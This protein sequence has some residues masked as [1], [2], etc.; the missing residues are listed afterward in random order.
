MEHILTVTLLLF[1]AGFLPVTC[2]TIKQAQPG[3]TVIIWCQHNV[4]V[5]GYIY[6]FKQNDGAVPMTIVSMLYSASLQSR[7][8]MYFNS[9]KK[10]HLVMDL[11]SKSTTLTIMNVSISDSGFYFCGAMEHQ[12]HFGSGTQL[13]V[14]EKK[15]VSVKNETGIS[16][17][18]LSS[19]VLSGNTK[20]RS[21]KK[22]L[23]V[24]NKNM[25]KRS[26]IQ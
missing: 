26:L 21:R 2:S 5:S 22:S 20:D 16:K 7:V 14:K 17:K 25:M 3:V 9:F 11:F 24:K 15:V 19:W 8:Q 23:N 4:S 13:E 10:D 18:V 6:W 1:G 12:V